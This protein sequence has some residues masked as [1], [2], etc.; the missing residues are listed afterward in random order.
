M[1]KK[2]LYVVY[3]GGLP[4][5][6]VYGNVKACWE[7]VQKFMDTPYHFREGKP[8]LA[9]TYS[10]FNS[11]LKKENVMLVYPSTYGGNDSISVDTV[12]LNEVF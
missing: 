10:R 3:G 11:I 9:L 4:R 12:E 1:T 5:P 7:T 6:Y 2:Y 8:M